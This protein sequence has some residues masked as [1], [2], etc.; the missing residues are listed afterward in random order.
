MSSADF[1]LFCVI[2][3]FDLILRLAGDVDAELFEGSAVD[4]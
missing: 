1:Y 3:L 4:H 2:K